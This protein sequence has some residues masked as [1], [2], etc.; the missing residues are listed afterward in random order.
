MASLEV[1]VSGSWPDSFM[2]KNVK[3]QSYGRDTGHRIC[4]LTLLFSFWLMW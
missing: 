4:Q 2:E 1:I 3:C